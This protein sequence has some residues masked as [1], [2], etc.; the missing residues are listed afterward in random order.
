MLVVLLRGENAH[1]CIQIYLKLQSICVDFLCL[2]FCY[3]S[4]SRIIMLVSYFCKAISSDEKKANHGMT[5][6]FKSR[7]FV[8]GEQPNLVQFK[9]STSNYDSMHRY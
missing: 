2:L 9:E 8:T 5:W 3:F 6:Q 1:I 4:F 7:L